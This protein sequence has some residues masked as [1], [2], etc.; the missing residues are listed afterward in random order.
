ME[1]DAPSYAHVPDGKIVY[2]CKDSASA[3]SGQKIR[4]LRN[5]DGPFI[6]IGHLYGKQN[7]LNLLHVTSGHDWPHPVNVEKIVV[8]PDKRPVRYLSWSV[9]PEVDTDMDQQI[10]PSHANIANP[11]LAEVGNRQAKYLD[12][13]PSK[14]AISSQ[15]CK[16][17]YE[18]YPPSRKII[19]W[20]GQL[21]GLVKSYPFLQFEGAPNGGVGFRS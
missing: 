9:E 21:H 6:V 2:M 10:T 15:A 4:F 5:F 18:S 16:F 13:L 19:A 14:S 8:I 20:H 7:L 3:K 17:I 11:D 1:F 12:A